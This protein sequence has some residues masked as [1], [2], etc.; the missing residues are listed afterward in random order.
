MKKMSTYSVLTF[1]KVGEE[2][3]KSKVAKYIGDDH[4]HVDR[5]I[6]LYSA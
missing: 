4:L 3:E 6:D 2:N 1:P 5:K